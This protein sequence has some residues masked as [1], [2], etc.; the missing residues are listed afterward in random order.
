M[1]NVDKALSKPPKCLFMLT[2]NILNIKYAVKHIQRANK[3]AFLHIDLLEGISKDSM[4]IKYI[5]QEIKPDGII[6]TRGHLVNCAKTE[7]LFT[8]QR[9]FL[10]DSLAVDTAVKTMKQVDPDAV[11]LL[12]AVIPKIIR[13]VHNKVNY[14]LIAGGLIEEVDEVDAALREGALAVSV[15]K[16][17]IWDKAFCRGLGD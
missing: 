14:P 6:T 12:P 10:L 2:G 9:V 3:R 7:G 4:G 11:E 17:E 15:T 16:E 1:D 13:R 8:I 5:A